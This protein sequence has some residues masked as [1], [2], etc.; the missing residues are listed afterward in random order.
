MNKLRG[1]LR[2][3][4]SAGTRQVVA[5]R[6]CL[7][8]HEWAEAMVSEPPHTQTPQEAALT[9]LC[10][11]V[12]VQDTKLWIHLPRVNVSE[13]TLASVHVYTCSH[14]PT[15]IC[16]HIGFLTSALVFPDSPACTHVYTFECTCTTPSFSS[17]QPSSPGCKAVDHKIS[18]KRP[19]CLPPT[20]GRDS[21][22]CSSL[23]D[24]LQ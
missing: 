8:R 21:L 24:F 19:P 10:L 4:H 14:T 5:R 11:G 16:V 17:S 1:R 22:P 18:W 20:E 12:R 3:D 6:F 23:A 15:C 2:R 13:L 9:H 7:A